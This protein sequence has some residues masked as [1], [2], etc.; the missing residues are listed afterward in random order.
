MDTPTPRRTISS[1]PAFPRSA[2]SARHDAGYR[3]LNAGLRGK[4]IA[5]VDPGAVLTGI[6]AR[7]CAEFG[8]RTSLWPDYG[9]VGD[10]PRDCHGLVVGGAANELAR[11]FFIEDVADLRRGFDCPQIVVIHRLNDGKIVDRACAKSRWM[12]WPIHEDYVLAALAAAMTRD[13]GN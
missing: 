13:S 4:H 12:A 2:A 6:V 7:A 8:G 3:T 5:V 9:M 1:G 10:L 11:V